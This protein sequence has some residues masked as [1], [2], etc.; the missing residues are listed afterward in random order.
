MP[1]APHPGR[2]M[3]GVKKELM[4]VSKPF[5]G[6][7]GKGLQRAQ[8]VFFKKK[9]LSAHYVPTTCARTMPAYRLYIVCT[10]A[11]RA[12]HRVLLLGASKHG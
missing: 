4:Y 6:E 12:R 3:R 5:G 11:P 2:T 9:V 8:Y 7:G 1:V 10:N